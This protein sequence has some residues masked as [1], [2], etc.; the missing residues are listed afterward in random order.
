VGRLEDF[1]EHVKSA[2]Y[3]QKAILSHEEMTQLIA[4]LSDQPG[5]VDT[6][7]DELH[8]MEGLFH[9]PLGHLEYFR[10]I[11]DEGFAV[12]ACGRHTSALD[13]VHTAYARRIHDRELIRDALLGFENILEL[14]DSGRQGDCY[15]CGRK[16]IM[17]GYYKRGYA[18]AAF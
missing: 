8:Y 11:P 17:R 9:L 13:V 5:V 12:C 18:Y 7:V 2:G 14:S 1:I 4:I 16:V 15:R 3:N 6:P 10:V